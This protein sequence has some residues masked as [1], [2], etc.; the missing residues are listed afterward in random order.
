MTA[1]APDA[2]RHARARA[3]RVLVTL[4]VL[5]VSAVLLLTRDRKSSIVP[6][7]AR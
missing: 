7:A 6:V 1:D 5:I 2:S 3:A 4:T